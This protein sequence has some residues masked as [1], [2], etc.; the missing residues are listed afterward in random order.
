MTKMEKAV[1]IL[2]A[3]T[4][5]LKDVL[6][7]PAVRGRPS[8]LEDTIHWVQSGDQDA[9]REGCMAGIRKMDEWQRSQVALASGI[10]SKIITEV[11][12]VTS[13]NR[14]PGHIRQDV[15]E[16]LADKY[17]DQIRAVKQSGK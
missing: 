9:Y 6:P 3:L 13:Q 11:A 16:A 2:R 10:P 14:K 12:G 15:I 5:P 1:I 4:E 7:P 17:D 8:F